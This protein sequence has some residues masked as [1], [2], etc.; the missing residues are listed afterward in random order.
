M[1]AS[2][3]RAAAGPCRT[4]APRSPR[5]PAAPAFGAARRAGDLPTL[6]EQPAGERQPRVPQAEAEQA[7]HHGERRAPL[8]QDRGVALGLA[9]ARVRRDGSAP[10]E[11]AQRPDRHGPHQRRWVGEPGLD[12][13]G[14]TRLGAVAD[15]DQDVAHEPIASG[16]L[17][18][19]AGEAPPEAGVVQLDELRE[20]RRAQ[21]VA[22][23]QLGLA[24]RA[25]E[26]VPGADREAVVA[27][28]DAIAHR[29]AEL[30]RYVPLVLDR[31]IRDAAPGIELVRRRER[32]GRAHLQAGA[33]AAAMIGLR[34]IGRQR[35][36]GEDLAEEQPGAEA[37]RYQV[38]VLAL[39]A[40]PGLLGQRLLQD[41]RRV[42]EHLDRGAEPAVHPAGQLLET[43]L[44]QVVV[45]AMAG[46]H[47]D[48]RA[49][50]SGQRRERVLVRAIV[51]ANDDHRPRLRPEGAG[52]LSALRV[53]REP[54]HVA[55]AALGNVAAI[56]VLPVARQ[57]GRGKADGLEAERPRP[58][59]DHAA[60]VSGAC[61]RRT[62]LCQLE[63][64]RMRHRSCQPS[65]PHRR[66]QLSLAAATLRR[67]SRTAPQAAAAVGWRSPE[68]SR[69]GASGHAMRQG[70]V[71]SRPPRPPSWRTWPARC[72]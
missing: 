70:S 5:Q 8:L 44:D 48:R 4:G 1:P 19:R 62:A 54:D 55:V 51:H 68:H 57:I 56:G 71:R 15:R 21:I 28:V 7:G 46:V 65:A 63:H 72:R 42:D 13:R 38:G 23:L 60:G 50:T 20:R 29:G 12:Q 9:V 16:A 24:C 40:D 67:R 35:E 18:R 59:A 66:G 26:L 32:V 30:P 34:R 31:E 53:A 52:A 10:Q 14:K 69:C 27:A 58:L 47:R 22:R 2:A 41:R 61:R 43:A 36:V 64:R 25:G 49:L 39:P 3:L 6:G 45:I 33:A 17:D 37:A 11:L